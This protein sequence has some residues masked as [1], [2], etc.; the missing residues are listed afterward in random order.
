[1]RPEILHDALILFDER[2]IEFK[3]LIEFIMLKRGHKQVIRFVGRSALLKKLKALALKS[4][5]EIMTSQFMLKDVRKSTTFDVFQ[6]HVPWND[7]LELDYVIYIGKTNAVRQAKEIEEKECD[8]QDTANIYG[9][10]D[11]CARSYDRIQCGENWMK[12]YLEGDNKL[13]YSYH[14]NKIALLFPPYLTLHQDY[15]PC[16]VRCNLSAEKVLLAEQLLIEEEMSEILSILRQHLCSL[17]LLFQDRIW[18]FS[19]YLHKDVTGEF[20][21][22]ICSGYLPLKIESS[23][24]NI[25]PKSLIVKN[26]MVQLTSEEGNFEFANGVDGNRLIVFS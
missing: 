23:R 5:L 1:M 25:K 14:L 19:S 21:D 16:S 9:Y 12:V 17:C 22:L 8:D 3:N 2:W 20:S 7:Q 18:Y 15:F 4:D 24:R 13:H 6:K 10:P 11:C 26:G